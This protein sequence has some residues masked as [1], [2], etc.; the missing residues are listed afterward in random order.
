[1][2]RSRVMDWCAVVC[3]WQQNFERL[4]WI[5]VASAEDTR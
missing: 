3:V 5:P 1:M 4:Y 2:A